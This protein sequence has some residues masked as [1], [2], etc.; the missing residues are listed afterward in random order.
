MNNSKLDFIRHWYDVRSPQKNT[1]ETINDLNRSIAALSDKLYSTKTHFLLEL[2]QNADDNSYF[3]G[4]EPELTFRLASLELEGRKQACLCIQNNEVGFTERNLEALFKVGASSK[5]KK[6]GFIGEKG[7]GFKSVYSISDCPYIFSAGYQ[8]KLPKKCDMGNGVSLGYIVPVWV[9]KT[10]DIKLSNTNIILPINT[11]SVSIEE[12][13]KKLFETSPELIL[14]LKK[15]NKITI[16]HEEESGTRK[17]IISREF[18]RNN[19]IVTL[20]SEKWQ[21]VYLESRSSTS[22][23]YKIK[24][25]QKPDNINIE[26]R[27]GVLSREICIAIPLGNDDY[28]GRLFAYLPVR[29]DTGLPF[30]VNADF[31]L[32]SSRENVADNEWNDWL[33]KEIP[34]LFAEVIE[35]VMCDDAYSI[36]EKM[37]VFSHIPIEADDRQFQKL[38][39]SIYEE[40]KPLKCV[41]AYKSND[42]E[43][44]ENCHMVSKNVKNILSALKWSPTESSPILV[45]DA[46]ESHTYILRK[47]DIPYLAKKDVLDLFCQEFIT[48][49]S[50]QDLISFYLFLQDEK[51]TDLDNYPWI[52]VTDGKGNELMVGSKG[53]I[54]YY[55]LESQDELSGLIGKE[56]V[57]LYFLRESFYSA[58][59][60]NLQSKEVFKFL[61]DT[62]S[63]YP[64]SRSNYSVDLKNIL[65]VGFPGNDKQFIEISEYILKENEIPNVFITNNGRISSSGRQLVVS[66]YYEELGWRR[67]WDPC[68][69]Q[70]NIIYLIGY[71]TDYQEQLLSKGVIKRFPLFEI[72]RKRYPSSPAATELYNKAR[73]AAAWSRMDETEITYPIIPENLL[74]GITEIIAK[75]LINF[76]SYALK[77]YSNYSG[78]GFQSKLIYMGLICEASYRNR[79]TYTKTG[80]SDLTVKLLRTAWLPT[81]KGPQRP[82]DVWCKT[83]EIEGMLGDTVPYLNIPLPSEIRYFFGIRDKLT[84]DFIFN[85]ILGLAKDR[86]KIES[87]VANKLYRIC[88]SYDLSFHLKNLTVDYKKSK[89]IYIQESPYLWYNVQEC[90]WDD[91]SATLDTSFQYL[92]K[93]YPVEL[94]SFFI[95]LGVSEKADADTYLKCW[96]NEQKK[97]SQL[98][99]SKLS[100]LYQKVF[101]CYVGIPEERWKEFVLNARLITS[102]GSFADPATFVFNDNSSLTKIFEDASEINIAYIPSQSKASLQKWV[103]FYKKFAVE[104]ITQ[105]VKAKL[106]SDQ[107]D[108]STLEKNNLTLTPQ[109]IVMIATWLHEMVP[110]IYNAI[111]A[112]GS[113]MAQLEEFTVYNTKNQIDIEYQLR[114]KNNYITRSASTAVYLDI[115]THEIFCN[116]NDEDWVIILASELA[117]YISMGRK[118]QGLDSF[119]ESV[120]CSTNIRRIVE[121]NWKIPSEFEHLLQSSTKAK[122]DT[123]PE[124]ESVDDETASTVKQHDSVTATSQKDTSES[125]SHQGTSQDNN[126]GAKTAGTGDNT[127]KNVQS[128][129][130]KTTPDSQSNRPDDQEPDLL[131]NK[132]SSTISSSDQIVNESPSGIASDTSVHQE[133]KTIEET[134]ESSQNQPQDAKKAN[135]TASKSSLSTGTGQ[136]REDKDTKEKPASHQQGAGQHHDGPSPSNSHKQVFS[137]TSVEQCDIDIP[138]GQ[139]NYADALNS[140]FSRQGIGSGG[141]PDSDDY[142]DEPPLTPE[143][144]KRRQAKVADEIRKMYS[145]PTTGKEDSSRNTPDKRTYS[146]HSS[147]GVSDTHSPHNYQDIS[148]NIKALF[149][150]PDNALSEKEEILLRNIAPSNDFRVNMNLVLA[151][152]YKNNPMVRVDLEQ[153]YHGRCQICHHTWKMANGRPFWIAAFLLQRNKGGVAHSSN[154]I[155]LCAEHFVKWLH[156]TLNTQMNFTDLVKGIG[157]DD[158]HPQIQLELAGEKLTLTYNPKHFFDLRTL[159]QV[160]D[161]KTSSDNMEDKP[162]EEIAQTVSTTNNQIPPQATATPKKKNQ[163][164][165]S[166]EEL[167]KFYKDK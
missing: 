4:V 105:C 134:S 24:E 18:D 163:T 96:E 102:S 158:P 45:S 161:E 19:E 115:N 52:P 151:I 31:I 77:N 22:F 7:I 84:F 150:I 20:N 144:R 128:D 56:F 164:F 82:N 34:P 64:F 2:I 59:Q 127:D 11:G 72:E 42:A 50:D 119:I 92:S 15:I 63:V 51:Y 36:D 40:L 159:L 76:W 60:S 74:S 46:L 116:F 135:S 157:E 30:L 53:E 118:I 138:L 86:K 83:E 104:T 126:K 97:N 153:Y 73:A 71:S 43:F 75:S 13:S 25:V 9:E 98:T 152:A 12:L 44:P 16:I 10:P 91:E 14:F 29:D 81:T 146:P 142:P 78:T 88:N 137:D 39:D 66:P 156:G 122:N 106:I 37:I 54:I 133:Q 93:H 41:L 136:D 67:I 57:Q 47:L 100:S 79:G 26:E 99:K 166:F 132:P 149:G 5:Q 89:I 1:P 87:A 111:T 112:L 109:C 69:S 160:F 62:W 140:K 129:I 114:T 148:D 125:Q 48:Q 95:S 162:P 124:S 3:D 167:S 68:S 32:T 65:T 117:Q 103:E 101:D 107:I 113:A 27:A 110:Y 90:L 17:Y 55:P 8:F 80:I 141:T 165:S 23:L 155:C 139:P 130:V 131:P 28:K 147:Q 38:I 120:L 121:K 58:V 21:D 70:V 145:Q 6:D 35:D 85:Y 33:W 143:M 61:Q 154:A 108:K 49:L 94:K 123:E